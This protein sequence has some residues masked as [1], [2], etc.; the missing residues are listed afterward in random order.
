MKGFSPGPLCQAILAPARLSSTL[1]SKVILNHA[2][3]FRIKYGANLVSYPADF[4]GNE[5]LEL[6]RVESQHGWSFQSRWLR[7][8]SRGFT[9]STGNSDLGS[10][11][12]QFS[13]SIVCHPFPKE[14]LVPGCCYPLLSVQKAATAFVVLDQGGTAFRLANVTK[15]ATEALINVW[16]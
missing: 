9:F 5:T 10:R 11:A 8:K 15:L 14:A 4:R 13:Y 6:R 7:A 12:D 1:S 2:I 3:D 16:T